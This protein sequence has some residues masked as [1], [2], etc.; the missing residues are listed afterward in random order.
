VKRYTEELPGF[1]S[2]FTTLSGLKVHYKCGGSG[3]PLL[4]L[5]GAGCDWREWHKNVYFLTR[6]FRVYV[7]DLPGYGLSQYPDLPVPFSWYA[8]FLNDFLETLHINSAHV[9]G[10]SLGGLSAIL[11]AL[12]YPQKTPKVILVASAG[13]GD[14]SRRG[15]MRLSFLRTAGM[16][17]GKKKPPVYAAEPEGVWLIKGR[18]REL[19]PSVLLIWGSKDPYF[20]LDYAHTAHKLIP[21]SN[22]HIFDGCAHA[23]QRECTEEFNELVYRFL[24]E[25]N[26]EPD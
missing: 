19:T 7:P 13:I 22:L 17:M 18:L 20:P 4:L 10:H 1:P 16:L 3:A 9:I 23:P 8:L 5:H 2:F 25:L 12:N 26:E 15:R 6:H 21:H 11:L 14:I 24:T